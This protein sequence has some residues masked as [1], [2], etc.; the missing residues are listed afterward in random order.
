MSTN[1]LRKYRS[2][3]LRNFEIKNILDEI[4][5]NHIE[6]Y[7]KKMRDSGINGNSWEKIA[8]LLNENMNENPDVDAAIDSELFKKLI[9]DVQDHVYIFP[10]E[11]EIDAEELI[12][13]FDSEPQLNRPLNAIVQNNEKFISLRIE[14]NRIL[15]LYRFDTI[16]LGENEQKT[17]FYVTCVLDFDNS[18]LHIRLRRHYLSKSTNRLISVLD[19]IK[20]FINKLDGDIVIKSFSETTVQSLL[21]NIFKEE[22]SRAENVISQH[23]KEQLTEETVDAKINNFLKNE[24]KMSEP[25]LYSD[26]VK[27]AFYQD[28][29]LHLDPKEFYN[30][31]IFAFTFLDKNFIK[32]STR[33]PKKDPI[34]NSK[35]YWNLKD[36]I[37]E[38]EE[39]SELAC[40]WKFNEDNFEKP[41]GE[42]FEFVE[43]SLKEKYGSIEIHYY[44]SPAVKRRLKES[45]V[46]YR[47]SKYLFEDSLPK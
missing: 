16:G 1:L 2:T 27:S 17:N 29:S 30:G 47:I 46:H 14:G 19:E 20:K 10:I 7:R 35:V 36:L 45:Y 28:L 40:Y 39:V 22:S 32:S 44:R 4:L 12:T 9:Y 21:Y 41:A 5:P 18:L 43:I 23:A 37:H 15:I 34:Y 11:S 38:Y 13:R 3:I 26:R 8:H 42:E 31:F 6:D 33:N 24:L 25:E